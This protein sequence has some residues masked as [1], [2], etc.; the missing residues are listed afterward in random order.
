MISFCGSGGFIDGLVQLGDLTIK[1]ILELGNEFFG[2]SNDGV[3]GGVSINKAAVYMNLS[4]INEAGF[5]TLY[6]S[7]CEKTF[8]RYL[9]P[10]EPW[11]CSIRCDWVFRRPGRILRTIANPNATELCP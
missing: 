7:L 1:R 5:Y 8:K 10:N 9:F 11:L 6:D 3:V 2:A 4:P